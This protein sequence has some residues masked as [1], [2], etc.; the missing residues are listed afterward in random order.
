MKNIFNSI[1][2][3]TTLH[4]VSDVGEV[5]FTRPR[6]R[7]NGRGLGKA[8]AEAEAGCSRPRRGSQKNHENNLSYRQNS[9]ATENNVG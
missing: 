2:Y 4:Y 7:Q 9:V 3:F 6:P 8:E 1:E 5:V